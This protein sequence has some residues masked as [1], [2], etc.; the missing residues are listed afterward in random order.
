MGPAMMLARMVHEGLGAF[1]PYA[2]FRR[3]RADLDRLIYQE[4]DGASP[5]DSMLDMLK[6]M[7]DEAGAGFSREALR[8]QLVTLIFA[9]HETSAI[10]LSWGIHWLHRHPDSLAVLRA[11]LDGVAH[12]D[13]ETLSRLPYLDAVCKE[14]LRLHPTVPEVIRKLNEPL[15]LQSVLLPAGIPV[16]ACIV[17]T[18]HRAELYPDPGTFRPERFLERRFAA[19][20]FLPFG[21]GVHRCAGEA[22]A[23]L[24]IKAILATLVMRRTF[25]LV[26]ARAATPALR[27]ITMEPRGGVPVT[28]QRRTP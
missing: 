17:A 7:R 22:F 14:T 23:W 16:A 28:M 10:G 27:S 8:D 20:E 12:L 18:H 15:Q 2:R 5:A 3:A 13:A 19:H 21:G 11:E 1:G 25:T 4:I 6:G 26:D 9:G 24:E